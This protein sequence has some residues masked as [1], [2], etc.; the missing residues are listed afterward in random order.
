MCSIE[1][2]LLKI[3]QYSQENTSVGVSFNNVVGC[4]ASCQV[5]CQAVANHIEAAIRRC[6]AK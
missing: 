6:S 2:A 5:S 1:K 3:S 4:E